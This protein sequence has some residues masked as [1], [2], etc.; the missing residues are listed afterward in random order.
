MRFDSDVIAS[1]TEYTEGT[2]KSGVPFL[3]ER[4]VAFVL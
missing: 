1:L 2:F 4:T 3:H